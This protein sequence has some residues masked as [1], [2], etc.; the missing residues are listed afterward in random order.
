M[1]NAA[2]L[3]WDVTQGGQQYRVEA[4]S[5][6]G[7]VDQCGNHETRCDLSNL[8]CGQVYTATVVAQHSD[9]TSARSESVSI[10]TG[11]LL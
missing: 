5:A 11:M 8:Q 1:N 2:T 9:C 6:D 4:V 10:K 3:S 7:H